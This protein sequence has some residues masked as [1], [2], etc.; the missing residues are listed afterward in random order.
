MNIRIEITKPL[1]LRPERMYAAMAGAIHE[2]TGLLET[3]VRDRE[4]KE[5]AQRIEGIVGTPLKYALPVEYGRSAG[6]RM[7]PVSAL[8]PWV[9]RFITLER[10]QTAKGVAFAIARYMS[11]R[12][13]RSWRQS[14][15]GERMF[16]RGFQAAEPR[17][18][19]VL[20][21]AFNGAVKT[22]ME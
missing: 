3:A 14:P 2:G 9:E 6:K 15:P 10:G 7:P 12:G 16:L 4:V 8:I 13:T 1:T 5:F 17:I 22:V 18:Q 21:R 19:R 11:Q 20:E